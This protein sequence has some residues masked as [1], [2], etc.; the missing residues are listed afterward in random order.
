MLRAD[1]PAASLEELSARV[2]KSPELQAVCHSVAHDLGHA[3]LANLGG[4]ADN[5]LALRNDVCG[6]GYTHGVV[7]MALADS[8]D[9][10]ADM[11]A[12]CDRSDGPCWHGV[13]H[14][15]MFSQAYDVDRAEGL[16]RGAPSVRMVARCAEGVYMQLFTLDD[17]AAHVAG[18]AFQMPTSATAAQSCERTVDPF[19]W[20]CWYYSPTVWLQERPEDWDGAVRWCDALDSVSGRGTCVAGVGSRA[21]KHHI[22][23]IPFAAGVCRRAPADVRNRC[24]AGMGSYWAVHWHGEKSR[25]S[26]CSLLDDPGLARTCRRANV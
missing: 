5:A 26:I 9:A 1:G 17:G 23:D 24:L 15:L 6:G 3:A 11:L 4:D 18:P 13:G 10:A 16:C 19:A 22:D 7:E 8:T 12:I 2:E 14:G 20:A 21:V 25:D